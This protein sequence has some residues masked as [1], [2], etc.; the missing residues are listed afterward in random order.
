MTVAT[1]PKT[2]GALAK[3]E[4]RFAWA[5]LLPTITVI[6]LVIILPLLAIFWISF[7]PVALSDLRP[8]QVIVKE[9]LKSSVFPSA[10]SY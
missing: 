5:L 6:S 10:H 4:E 1:P 3:R 9:N 2:C 7:K 8:V